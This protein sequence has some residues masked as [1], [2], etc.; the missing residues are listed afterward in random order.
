[1]HVCISTTLTYTCMRVRGETLVNA[2]FISSNSDNQPK[3][4]S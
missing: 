1:M 4:D 3:D 2:V